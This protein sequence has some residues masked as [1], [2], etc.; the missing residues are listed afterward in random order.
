MLASAENSPSEGIT[1]ETCAG[2]NDNARNTRVA[3]ALRIRIYHLKAERRARACAWQERERDH[4]ALQED[5]LDQI[6]VDG[7]TL[8]RLRALVHQLE[9]VAP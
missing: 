8:R 2:R 3:R 6:L 5:E 1:G 9:W 4:R 7:L